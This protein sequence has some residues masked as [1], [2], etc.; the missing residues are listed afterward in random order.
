MSAVRTR[1]S[2]PENAVCSSFSYIKW[3]LTASENNAIPFYCQRMLASHLFS[4]PPGYSIIF[5]RAN[6]VL[7]QMIQMHF[8]GNV[9]QKLIYCAN[10][11][12]ATTV[13]AGPLK[14]IRI[15]DY[16]KYIHHRSYYNVL[17]EETSGKAYI[18]I[19]TSSPRTLQE[20]YCNVILASTLGIPNNTD[21][22]Q[23]PI[24]MKQYC[25]LLI[26]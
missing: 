23:L 8:N 2:L 10:E 20:L 18:L 4:P 13:W 5:G 17:V 19:K 24:S 6:H 25:K 26:S 22:L 21:C 3:S 16:G 15:T 1:A 14:K 9:F 7:L 11:I 12:V